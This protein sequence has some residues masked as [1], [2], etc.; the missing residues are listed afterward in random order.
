MGSCASVHMEDVGLPKKLS[1]ALSLPSKDNKVSQ[2]AASSLTSCAR[3]RCSAPA[4]GVSTLLAWCLGP[5]TPYK[6]S[7][8][9][10]WTARHIICCLG[11]TMAKKTLFVP[12]PWCCPAGQCLGALQRLRCLL[13]SFA[14]RS[15]TTTSPAVSPV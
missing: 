12:V 9:P 14:T 2:S 10:L 5:W 4:A 3:S 13:R 7:L 1:L 11:V 8:D 15:A 6:K